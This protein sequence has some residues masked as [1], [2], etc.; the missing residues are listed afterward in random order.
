MSAK[1]PVAILAPRLEWSITFIHIDEQEFYCA[2]FVLFFLG[3]GF[4]WT[5]CVAPGQKRASDPR[6]IREPWHH[7]NSPLRKV[8]GCNDAQERTYPNGGSGS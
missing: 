4:A 8:P 7:S 5:G 2:F 6:P 1:K 3:M